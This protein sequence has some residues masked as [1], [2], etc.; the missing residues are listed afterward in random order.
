MKLHWP[1]SID[2]AVALLGADDGAR[3]HAGG[4]TLVAMMNAD[5]LAPSSL[6]FLRRIDALT[7]IER[8]AEGTVVIGAMTTHETVEHSGDFGPGQDVVRLAAAR[9]AHPPIRAV[10]T[11]GGSIA[12]A[13]PAADYPAAL[14]AADARMICVGADGER[15]IPAIDF[16]AD[17]F[18]TALA[19]GEIVRAVAVP[20]APEGSAAVYDK[21]ARV[22][23]D[24]AIVSVAAVIAMKD[25]VC[26]HARL[27]GGACAATP[28]RVSAAEA[29]LVGSALSDDDLADAVGL[30]AA[31]ADPIDDVRGSAAYRRKVLA[32]MAK[33]A[34][35]QAR[36]KSEAAA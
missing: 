30:F 10:G 35:A 1:T 33:R 9:I 32:R 15:E 31:E 34:I 14:V 7:G 3:P 12:H 4:A 22:E 29:R 26:T 23:G 20:P 18:E 11:I 13:D 25:G 5:L 2:E 24:Y 16:F 27:V 6:V 28:L 36:E 8:Q 17:Y 21:L 19:P